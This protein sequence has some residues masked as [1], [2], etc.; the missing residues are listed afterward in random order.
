M[1]ED[2]ALKNFS[3]LV[4]NPQSSDIKNSGDHESLSGEE[5]SLID[6]DNHTI[7]MNNKDNDDDDDDDV[8]DI[9]NE[10]EIKRKKIQ[11]LKKDFKNKTITNENRPI[12]DIKASAYVI[13]LILDSLSFSLIY[14]I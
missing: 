13:F 9:E 2:N 4:A 10:A 8:D 1:N 12:N 11:C 5:N 6:M 3:E 7:I 14:Q